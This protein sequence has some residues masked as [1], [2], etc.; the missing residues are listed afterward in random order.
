[1]TTLID[2]VIAGSSLVLR[3][4]SYIFLRWIPGHHFPPMIYTL[5]AIYVPLFIN[6]FFRTRFHALSN[7]TSAKI[8]IVKRDDQSSNHLDHLQT[9][10]D[11]YKNVACKKPGESWLT[12]LIGL[13]CSSPLISLATF[14]VNLALILSVT[15]LI[16]RAKFLY[17]VEDLSFARMGYISPTMANLLVR[18]T[19]TSR[20]PIYI[21][22]R[23]VTSVEAYPESDWQAAGIITDL[24]NDTDFTGTLSF[25][26]PNSPDQKY[27]WITSNNHTGFFTVPPEEGKMTRNGDFSFLTSSCLKARVPYN[28][29]DHPLSISGF[30]HMSRVLK[31]VSGVQFMLFLGDFIYIDVPKRFGISV[32]DYRREYRQVYASPDW[33]LVGQNLSWIHVLDDHE[34][35]NDWDLR[36]TGVYKAAVD[37]WNHYQTKINPPR[38]AQVNASL[39]PQNDATYFQFTQGPA[40]FFLLD[41]R[42]YRNSSTALPVNATEKTML[43]SDQLSNL[44]A[45]LRKPEP[46]GVKWKFVISSVPFTKNWQVNGLDTWAGFLHE[47]QIIL[48]SMWDAGL[49]SDISIVILSGDRHEFAATAFPPPKNGKWP[50]RATVHEFSVSPMSQF[51]LPV[52]TYKQIDDEDVEVK[53]IHTGNSKFGLINIKS[54]PSGQ[55]LQYV[56]Y[57]NGKKAWSYVLSSTH[58]TNS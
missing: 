15:D 8:N 6:N 41:C 22:F 11:N 26:L 20:L 7:K 27:Q 16:Y 47:R 4:L 57:V 53:Y 35:A 17:S 3:I 50:S 13:P 1:M 33:P 45:F 38:A 5:F 10:S 49:E 21:S 25:P 51:Y 28:P 48:E 52:P 2:G 37:P 9:E 36:V 58:V 42:T 14:S 44:L 23:P 19:N 30:K 56:L 34:I 12:A 46:E 24:G 18:E 29:F 43:G 55:K 31:N 39:S 40:S 54:T 32:E